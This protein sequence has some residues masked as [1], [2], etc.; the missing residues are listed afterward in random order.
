MGKTDEALLYIANHHILEA[1]D[2]INV[3]QYNYTMINC[4][5]ILV[6]TGIFHDGNFLANTLNV[7][8]KQS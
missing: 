2:T 3:L 8:I 6:R 1:E 5:Q 4:A 7:V